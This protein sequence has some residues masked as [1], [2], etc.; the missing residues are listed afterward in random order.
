[1]SN[2][3]PIGY[4]LTLIIV[5]VVWAALIGF[6]VLSF[7]IAWK[8]GGWESFWHI[9]GFLSAGLG[10]IVL[11]CW[12]TALIPFDSKY[13]QMYRVTGEVLSVSNVISESGGDL[14][15]TPVLT[16]AGV[17]RDVIVDDP[18]AVNL[19]G[20][21]VDFTCTVTWHYQAADT[22]G[23]RIYQIHEEDQ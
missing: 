14:T 17:D 23:C 21:T 11:F 5:M 16:V 8:R 19:G 7:V 20:K 9:P 15:R 2:F 22:Y 6:G 18:R 3:E 10:V 1:M 12:V 13:H 4:Q